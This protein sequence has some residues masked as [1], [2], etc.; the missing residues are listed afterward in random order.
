[1][2]RT[3]LAEYF[4]INDL[5]VNLSKTN[6]MVFRRG[7]SLSRKDKFNYK[8]QAIEIV[9][10]YTYLGIVMSY[11][12]LFRQACNDRMSKARTALASALSLCSSAN[13][14]SWQGRTKLFDSIVVNSLLYAA[15]IWAICLVFSNLIK[16]WINIL[17]M[18]TDRLVRNCYD[19]LV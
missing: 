2:W 17:K 19:R 6:V 8:G 12:G 14:Y 4:D 3:A 10:T 1:M 9:N 18:N 5:T 7:G 15:P 13:I 16:F 11:T